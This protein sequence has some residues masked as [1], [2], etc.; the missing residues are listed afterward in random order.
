MFNVMNFFR[1]PIAI[2][3]SHIVCKPGD[4]VCIELPNGVR[5]SSIMKDLSGFVK[6]MEQE[7]GV[8]VCVFADGIRVIGA[9][10]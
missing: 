4:V 3:F 1:R 9:E 2:D 10:Q 8:K 7:A 5:S 6:A